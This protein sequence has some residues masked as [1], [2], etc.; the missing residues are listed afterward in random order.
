ML[1]FLQKILSASV[2]GIL[3]TQSDAAIFS[4][5]KIQYYWQISNE[6]VAEVKALINNDE[7]QGSLGDI[8]LLVLTADNLKMKKKQPETYNHFADSQKELST[9]SQ[10]S[11]QKIIENADHF[12]PIKKPEIV[13]EELM[14]FFD[15]I[16]A[17]IPAAS[18][19]QPHS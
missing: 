6:A 16:E 4:L 19:S 17:D 18:S 5:Y 15:K 1:L 9:L 11:S 3:L 2:W 12:F 7:E 14:D 8:P 10:N 13:I